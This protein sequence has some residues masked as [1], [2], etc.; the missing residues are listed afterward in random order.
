MKKDYKQCRQS[1]ARQLS[2][3][4]AADFFAQRGERADLEAARRILRRQG[5][6]TPE[7]ED[8]LE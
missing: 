8:R 4:R 3:M 5:G 2:A 1:G 6:Q 7:P